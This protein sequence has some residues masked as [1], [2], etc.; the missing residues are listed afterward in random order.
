M[1]HTAIPK[2]V[3][4]ARLKRQGLVSLQ[5]RRGWQ[6]HEHSQG[7]IFRRRY[8][9]APIPESTQ[10]RREG[11]VCCASVFRQRHE[12]LLVTMQVIHVKDILCPITLSASQAPLEKR[13]QGNLVAF[14]RKLDIHRSQQPLS[15]APLTT[16]FIFT[17]LIVYT[18]DVFDLFVWLYIL[19]IFSITIYYLSGIGF[20]D[21]QHIMFCLL[22]SV[23]NHCFPNSIHRE[24]KG[25]YML[26]L[27]VVTSFRSTAAGVLP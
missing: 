19:N 26:V 24:A 6:S 3:Y 12:G 9:T 7:A 10:V 20:V 13:S 1:T 27:R 11:L 15:T 25:L 21:S 22:Y 17:H 8:I 5:V 16:V 14:A 18:K 2:E 23:L 4:R